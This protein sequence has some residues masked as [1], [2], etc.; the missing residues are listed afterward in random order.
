MEDSD[1][2]SENGGHQRGEPESRALIR[3]ARI[4]GAALQ[5]SAAKT[6]FGLTIYSIMRFF[7]WTDSNTTINTISPI[8]FSLDFHRGWKATISLTSQVMMAASLHEEAESQSSRAPL[9]D[10]TPDS[11]SQGIEPSKSQRKGVRLKLHQ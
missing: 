4:E 6:M 2:E 8:L 10:I 7:L 9:R 3:W 5:S 1:E 11:L